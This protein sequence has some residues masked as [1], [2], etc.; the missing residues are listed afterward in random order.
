MSIASRVMY[1]PALRQLAWRGICVAVDDKDQGIFCIILLASYRD[2][3]CYRDIVYANWRGCPI[4]HCVLYN[5]LRGPKKARDDSDLQIK[6]P[7]NDGT[8]DEDA[9]IGISW[10]LAMQSI[11]EPK[12]GVEDASTN[13]YIG[14]GPIIVIKTCKHT[15]TECDQWT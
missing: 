2:T 4:C 15:V 11:F 7:I 8:N 3:Q 5:A 14:L 6:L 13:K 9:L 12:N 1:V 10:L